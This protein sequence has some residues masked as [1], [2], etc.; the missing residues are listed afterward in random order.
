MELYEDNYIRLRQL[1]PDLQAV[2]PM[3]VSRV[4]GALD[5]HLRIVERCKYTTTLNLTYFFQDRLGWF[6]AP[7]LRIRIYHD[8]QTAEVLGC[9]RRRGVREAEYDGVGI[10]HDLV[11][12][13][14]VNRFLQKWLGYGLRQ[15][16]RFRPG[17]DEGHPA[18]GNSSEALVASR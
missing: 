12:K 8:A 11:Q 10:R 9:G 4:P 5:L 7:D 16:H 14:R 1:I 2:G 3:T 15:G 17:S 18:S 13:W 6:P